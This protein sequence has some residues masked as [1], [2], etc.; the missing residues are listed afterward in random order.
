MMLELNKYEQD[1]FINLD[2]LP[3][4]DQW[5]NIRKDRIDLDRFVE[6]IK[7]RIQRKNDF[8]FNED[9]TQFK[10][11][12]PFE[13]AR[14]NQITYSI[15]WR[16]DTGELNEKER[17]LPDPKWKRYTKKEWDQLTGRADK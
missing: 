13:I 7:K 1:M 11:V 8:V 12:K 3:F 5:L 9:Y 15:E 16:E 2:T 6:V 10:R 14:S 4:N 17:N